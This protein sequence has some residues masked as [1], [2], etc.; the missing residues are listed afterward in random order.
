MIQWGRLTGNSTAEKSVSYPTAYTTKAIVTSNPQYKANNHVNG[1]YHPY[2][3]T[4]TGFKAYTFD[5][6]IILDWMSIGY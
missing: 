3:V 5:S 6:S 1:I 4:K 2:S